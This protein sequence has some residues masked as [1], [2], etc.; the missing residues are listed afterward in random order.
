MSLPDLLRIASPGRRQAA[1]GA[2]AIALSGVWRSPARAGEAAA[3]AAAADLKFAL[4][5]IAPRFQA[6]TGHVLKLTFGSSGNFTQQI[7]QGAPFELFLSA[8]EQYVFQLAD[9]GR[10]RDR[11]TLYAVG[12]VALFAP[13]RSPLVVDARLEGL[14]RALDAGDIKR[15]AI[16]NPEHAPYGRAAR[17]VLRHAGLW[18]RIEPLLVLGEN[19]S[20]ALQFAASGS[21][22]G[23]I[24]P[25]SLSKAPPVA[26]LGRFATIPAD[27]H[28]GEPL[29]QRMVLTRHAGAAARAFYDYL[30][31]PAARAILARYGFALPGEPSQ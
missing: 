19:A 17:A 27:W 30:Q 18:S 5:E 6:D 14:R 31:G 7:A 11:G 10:V 24:V 23:G 26:A 3:I 25:L 16:A 20:Q 29:R 15:F 13:H 4:A 1:A 8:D 9:A 28:A 2:L 22:Q 12:R 21:S